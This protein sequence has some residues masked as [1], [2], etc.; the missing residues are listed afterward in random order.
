MSLVSNLSKWIMT[1]AHSSELIGNVSELTEVDINNIYEK[2]PDENAVNYTMLELLS[3]NNQIVCMINLHD[4]GDDICVR[5]RFYENDKIMKNIES[6]L[7]VAKEEQTTS[8][9]ISYVWQDITN[10][11][12]DR[13]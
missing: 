7:I 9:H 5:C 13:L 4:R 6:S 2:L 8:P 3:K 10:Y 11:L 12:G 1:M